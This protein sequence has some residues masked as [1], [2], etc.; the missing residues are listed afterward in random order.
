MHARDRSTDSWPHSRNS[1]T[2]YFTSSAPSAAKAGEGCCSLPNGF[3]VLSEENSRFTVARTAQ[4]GFFARGYRPAGRRGPA[5]AG[6][7]SGC[8]RGHDGENDGQRHARTWPP[9]SERDR[10]GTHQAIGRWSARR[11][12]H[13]EAPSLRRARPRNV[14]RVTDRGLV[15]LRAIPGPTQLPRASIAPDPS[16]LWTPVPHGHPVPAGRPVAGDHPDPRALPVAGVDP[17][18]R[19]VRLCHGP[20]ARSAARGR[21]LPSSRA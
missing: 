10:R 17:A 6:G 5:P 9:L 3:Y 15:T 18:M 12:K 2:G 13:A 4:H 21:F 16:V 19:R 1:P 7:R 14:T 8:R 20:A 11:A